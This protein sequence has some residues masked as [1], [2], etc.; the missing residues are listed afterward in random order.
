MTGISPSDILDFEVYNYYHRRVLSEGD[1]V[2]PQIIDLIVISYFVLVSNNPLMFH[3]SLIAELE[4]AV[5]SKLFDDI[6]QQNTKKMNAV[7]LIDTSSYVFHG[8]GV[9]GSDD[10]AATLSAGEV[11]GIVIVCLVGIGVFITLLMDCQR[12]RRSGTRQDSPTTTVTT[13]TIEM[14]RRDIIIT[15]IIDP[16]VARVQ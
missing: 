11:V 3:K 8:F 12:Q 15:E 1:V 4:Q 9:D 5:D 16:A 13:P 7:G 6:L 14:V 2:Q 10:Y